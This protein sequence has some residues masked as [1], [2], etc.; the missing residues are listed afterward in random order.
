MPYEEDLTCIHG[1]GFTSRARNAAV[2]MLKILKQQKVE[3]GLV[4]HLG[5]GCGLQTNTKRQ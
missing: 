1:A 4:A 3:N 5:C 2:T